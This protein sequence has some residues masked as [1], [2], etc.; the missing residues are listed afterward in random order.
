MQYTASRSD[1][2][3][4]F[5]RFRPWLLLAPLLAAGCA[6]RATLESAPAPAVTQAASEP[7]ASLYE[8]LGGLPAINA[9]VENFI[10]RLKRDP[11][12]RD[13][14]EAV[15]EPRF[16]AKLI[17]Q[18]GELSGGPQKYSGI[19][20]R[21]LHTGMD[22]SEEE[23]NAVVSALNA[24]L[25]ELKVPDRE[26]GEV[27]NALGPLKD[28]IVA[29][30][31]STMERLDT[32]EASLA[33]IE[34]QV[35]RVLARLEKEQT[36]SAPP[37]LA[38]SPPER[39]KAPAQGQQSGKTPV[40]QPWTQAERDLVPQLIE[41]YQKTSRAPN[42]GKRRDLIGRSLAHSRFLQDD[43]EVVDLDDLRGQPVVLIIMRGFGGAVCLHCSTQ[44][45]ALVK[46]LPQFKQ[47][48]AR[49]FVVY[50][51]DADT[52]PVF[53]ES[54]RAFD[55]R[56]RAPFPILLDIDLAAVRAFRIEGNVAK[57]TTLILDPQGIVRWA[58]VGRQPSDR[59][60]MELV[61]RQLDLV[62][63]G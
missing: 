54:I 48:N 52:V 60:S 4:G 62:K 21:V 12:V 20:M 13:R 51:G 23:F 57:P 55:S 42:A 28:Q 49:V 27:L 6:A 50:P 40:R 10:T 30:P 24:S 36:A 39:A 26:Q 14:F 47:R 61:L 63:A 32:L 19:D 25:R 16:R 18:I 38:A 59:P 1:S 35:N 3:H 37:P 29:R 46:N 15:N 43:G 17:E 56:F 2:V 22:I 45:L 9:V 8:R 44:M 11:V 33:R 53:I 7:T 58:Y 34:T 31:I 5:P 41:R